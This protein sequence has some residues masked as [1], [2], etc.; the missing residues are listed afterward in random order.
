M[1][2]YRPQRR[3][4]GDF[5]DSPQVIPL[6]YLCIGYV[7]EF[8]ER[9]VLESAE[10]G[11]RLPPRSLLHFDSWDGRKDAALTRA[12]GDPQIWRD[13]FPADTHGE[14][15]NRGRSVGFSRAP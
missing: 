2:E 13:I 6:A 14:G 7:R 1:G 11:K 9:P 4:G 3:V 8:P 5:L 15:R 12:I 10:W